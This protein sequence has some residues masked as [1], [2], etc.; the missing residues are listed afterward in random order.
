VQ[1]TT[2]SELL[3]ERRVLRIVDVLWFLFGVEVIQ[4]AEEFVETVG[5]GQEL[6]AVAEVVLPNWPVA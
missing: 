6:I 4:V 1:D 5:R 2:R 3:A